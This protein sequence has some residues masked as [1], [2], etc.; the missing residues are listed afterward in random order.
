MLPSSNLFT[1]DSLPL[2]QR[3]FIYKITFNVVT[4]VQTLPAFVQSLN[5]TVPRTGVVKLPLN[6]AMTLSPTTFNINK[7]KLI[8]LSLTTLSGTTTL[9]IMTISII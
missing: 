8:T 7:S 2:K 6:G 5:C 1:V 9:S 4:D 3:I